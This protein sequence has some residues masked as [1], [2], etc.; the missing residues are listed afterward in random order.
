MSDSYHPSRHV[1][2]LWR[3][4]Y[5]IVGAGLLGTI[6]LLTALAP[7]IAPFDPLAVDMFAIES[8]PDAIHLLGTDEVGRDVFS[9]LLYGARVSVLV[10]LSAVVVQLV[11]GVTL[12]AV[13]GYFG[14]LADAVVM[15][16][17]DMVMCFPFYSIAITLAALFG[18][19]L[20]NVV[21]IIGFLNWTGL[22]R[23]VRAEFLSLREREFVQAARAIGVSDLTIIMRHLL[24]NA[25][26][27]ILVY[28]TLAVATA[29]LAE[30][31]LSFLGLGVRPPQPSWGNILSAAQ[32][33]RVLTY[34]WWLWLPAGLA[35]VT[36]VLG[37]N[38]LG[39]A[40]SRHLTPRS[41]A[42]LAELKSPRAHRKDAKRVIKQ[43][44]LHVTNLSFPSRTSTTALDN[45]D[46]R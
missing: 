30:S 46:A 23:L 38:F 31:A 27:P 43:D 22:A 18:A 26:A 6:L 41:S 24:R 37:I 13:A 40:L 17:T 19:S 8:P 4:P 44:S 15:R 20:W 9:R 32:S 45:V 12:G 16:L 7:L 35:I 33:M 28:S 3:D 21:I 1:R 36:F 14:G 11:I 10:G 25:Y 34:Q 29:V 39:E 5:F 42:I 2:R